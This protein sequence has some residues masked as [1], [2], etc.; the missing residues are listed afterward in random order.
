MSLRSAEV[1]DPHHALS[2]MHKARQNKSETV[3]VSAERLC[4]L[5]YD[6]FV[7]TQQSSGEVTVGGFFID[8]L[9]HHLQIKIIKENPKMFQAAIQFALKEQNLRKRFNLQ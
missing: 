9:Y 2:L 7:E 3:Q 1:C 5:T 6:A 4:T 8:A